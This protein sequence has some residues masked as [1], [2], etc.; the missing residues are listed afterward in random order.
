M[1]RIS[2][3]RSGNLVKVASGA[4]TATLSSLDGKLVVDIA[5]K[6]FIMGWNLVEAVSDAAAVESESLDKGVS[7]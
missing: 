7:C 6:I 1:A 4:A 2:A 3:G 5:G